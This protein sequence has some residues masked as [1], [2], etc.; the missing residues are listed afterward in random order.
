MNRAFVDGAG[1]T[2]SLGGITHRIAAFVRQY[3]WPRVHVVLD[4]HS[5][6]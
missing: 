5:G 2:P 3:L 4:L 1:V 6:G